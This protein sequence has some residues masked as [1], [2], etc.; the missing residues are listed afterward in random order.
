GTAPEGLEYSASPAFCKI[1][2][3]LGWPCVHLPMGHDRKGLPLGVQLVGPLYRERELLIR[4]EQLHATI[5]ER[6]NA[7][8]LQGFA[9]DRCGR[10]GPMGS[11]RW[12]LRHKSPG[13][14]HY[15]CYAQCRRW[16]HRRSCTVD[17]RKNCT[18]AEATG[19]CE[20][21][22]GGGRRRWYAR[23]VARKKR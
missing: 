23:H 16:W 13:K 10:V 20:Q 5:N 9:A 14:G 3:V 11:S 2:P 21:Q 1:W 15:D 4:R 7:K 22:A 19:R 12:P 18:L 6:Q 17:R 8:A